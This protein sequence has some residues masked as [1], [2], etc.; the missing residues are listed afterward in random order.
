M[1]DPQDYD[2]DDMDTGPKVLRHSKHTARKPHPCDGCTFGGIKPGES[3]HVLVTLDGSEMKIERFCSHGERT[4]RGACKRD[5][6][7]WRFHDEALR[8]AYEDDAW[9]ERVGP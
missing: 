5:E 6:E 7:G 2:P 1:I 9:R 8:E 3:Y 4:E